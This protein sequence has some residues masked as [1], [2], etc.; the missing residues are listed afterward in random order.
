M[1]STAE[2]LEDYAN[3]KLIRVRNL[4]KSHFDEDVRY[5][6]NG[7]N[8]REKIVLKPRTIG[9]NISLFNEEH[10]RNVMAILNPFIKRGLL[11]ITYVNGKPTYEQKLVMAM[12]TQSTHPRYVPPTDPDSP[13]YGTSTS[14][15]KEQR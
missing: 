11:K 15:K 1:R 3:L 14:K 12:Y 5:V 10:A 7:T 8:R 4:T 2:I 6:I 9:E 13:F